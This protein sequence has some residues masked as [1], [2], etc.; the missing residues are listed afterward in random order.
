MAGAVADAAITFPIDLLEAIVK[1]A[2]AKEASESALGKFIT[3]LAQKIAAK[4]STKAILRMSSKMAK[5]ANIA[6]A[7]AAALDIADPYGYS[8]F[9]SNKY[10]ADIRDTAEYYIQVSREEN[11]TPF[12]IMFDINWM[13]G[14]VY[15]K[16]RAKYV[17][18]L[19]PDAAREI[20]GC[21]GKR[22]TDKM[23]SENFVDI[24]TLAAEM[25]DKDPV[26]RD[27]F[28][29]EKIKFVNPEEAKYIGLYTG[30]STES[31]TGI[32][33]NQEGIKLW[34]TY[35]DQMK[36]DSIKKATSFGSPKYKGE[37]VQSL[38]DYVNTFI[39]A[40]TKTYRYH[41]LDD[42]CREPHKEIVDH[43]MSFGVEFMSKINDNYGNECIPRMRPYELEEP[44]P[45]L[46]PNVIYNFCKVGGPKL[47][48][49]VPECE[50]ANPEDFNVGFNEN[51]NLCV[52]SRDYCDRMALDYNSQTQD[53]DWYP[54]QE[55]MELFFPTG[56]T[57]TRNVMR[58]GTSIKNCDDPEYAADYDN[59][60]DC[61]AQ[62]VFGI[63]RSIDKANAITDCDDNWKDSGYRSKEACEFART[64]SF[65]STVVPFSGVI[66]GDCGE[67]VFKGAVNEA[68]DAGEGF[69]DL[70]TKGDTSY[71]KD[72]TEAQID[73]MENR[74]NAVKDIFTGD[75]DETTFMTAFTGNENPGAMENM[76]LGAAKNTGA[77]KSGEKVVDV[78]TGDADYE[79]PMTYVDLAS[80]PFNPIGFTPAIPPPPPPSDW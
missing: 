62:N 72:K 1:R 68:Y 14:N 13:Y 69:K 79:D 16:A 59:V 41:Q 75:V 76:A 54:G 22:V 35:T 45:M 63:N 42:G 73:K 34:M 53:C 10:L 58:Y 44:I 17:S 80:I 40:F 29:Y 5:A 11:G 77:Y 23:V 55:G 46:L 20:F 37:Q 64:G 6:T 56:T 18:A 43:I 74:A 27:T 38:L 19:M 57:V 65:V 33:I 32:S 9:V 30:R 48:P 31:D 50:N 3:R 70:F 7:V 26:K 12:P 67:A 51:T 24:I 49:D 71:F 8:T 66:G 61:R 52:Y 60:H 39:I 2:T 28:I 15:D 36:R 4:Q 21:L 25:A 47:I 78:V